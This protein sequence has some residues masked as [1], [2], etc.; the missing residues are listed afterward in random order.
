MPSDVLLRRTLLLLPVLSRCLFVFQVSQLYISS[1][2]CMKQHH[3]CTEKQLFISPWPSCCEFPAWDTA[4]SLILRVSVGVMGFTSC[5]WPANVTTSFATPLV[6]SGQQHGVLRALLSPH[7]CPW[8]CHDVPCWWAHV[9]CTWT[10]TPNLGFSSLSRAGAAA[11]PR[12]ALSELWSQCWGSPPGTRNQPRPHC[13]LHTS[14]AA[15][16]SAN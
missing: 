10:Y 15:K 16:E 14:S 13:V 7:V 8:A 6:L 5:P 12:C 2:L 9:L 11:S 4:G 3:K 1:R